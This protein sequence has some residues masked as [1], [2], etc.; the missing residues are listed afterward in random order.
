MKW[1]DA[2]EERVQ[3]VAH[4]LRTD[5]I[6]EVA[7]SH[8][9]CAYDAVMDSWKQSWLCKVI[10]GDSGDPVGITG[11][12]G[13]RIFLL[14]TTELT[15]TKNHRRMLLSCGKQWVDECIK[16]AQ[17][18]VHNW[19][20]AKNTKALKYLR[21]LGFEVSRPAPFGPSAALFCHFWREG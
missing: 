10:E 8:G 7:L 11:V 15:A 9:C 1:I 2:T 16:A 18:P 19:A 17:G 4:N 13:N 20:Y 21:Y 5:D 3:F 12:C 6:T 14:G